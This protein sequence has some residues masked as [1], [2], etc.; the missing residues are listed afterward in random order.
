M[1]LGIRHAWLVLGA[2][3]A[4]CG[5]EFPN[6]PT[7][8]LTLQVGSG[9]ADTLTVRD[10]ARLV[11]RVGDVRGDSITGIE[12][13]WQSLDPDLLELEPVPLP[14]GSK[15]KDSL[16]ARLTI[17]AIAHARGEA[18]VV[19]TVDR[20]GFHRVELKDTI[21]IL[22]RWL[23]VS[24]GVSHTCAIAADSSAYCWG[25][26]TDGALGN[27]RPLDSPAPSKVVGLGSLKFLSISAGDRNTCAIIVQRVAYCWGL[28]SLGRLGN[29]SQSSAFTPTPVSVGRT[30]NSISAGQT[31]CGVSEQSVSFCWGS[32][33]DLQL[34]SPLAIFD[35]CGAVPC[36]LTPLAV[37]SASGDTLLFSS[38][39]VAT[40]HTCGISNGSGNGRAFCWGSGKLE[41]GTL[42]P[43]YLLGDT[44]FQSQEPIE[45]APPLSSTESPPYSS[46]SAGD[47]HTCAITTSGGL[48]CWGGNDRGQLGV[49]SRTDQAKPV[50]ALAAIQFAGVTAG[51][52]HA[53]ALTPTGDAYCWGAGDYG[54][55]GADAQSTVDRLV[56]TLVSGGQRFHSLSAGSFHTCGLTTGG[57]VF[58]W[59]RNTSGQLGTTVPT[60]TCTVAGFPATSCSLIAT[61]VSEPID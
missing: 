7:D 28:G 40:V 42:N 43:I 38:V 3:G 33:S 9:S 39:D 60:E 11:L 41:A 31:S 37:R 46:L 4:A 10:T 29:G 35:T 55:L 44:I 14:A 5:E 17:Q 26:G 1:R 54:Q 34:G 52:S 27:G 61:R 13:D 12:V 56:P 18:V 57:A 32:N 25:S 24:A 58:C 49:D 36:S 8:T 19:A 48:N 2:L 47:R 30:F 50:A 16:T 51:N 20:P 15:S 53:C 6:E 22:E 23:S 21:T 45:V 59:G